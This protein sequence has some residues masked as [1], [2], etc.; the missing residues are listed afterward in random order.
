[1]SHFDWI[2]DPEER[3]ALRDK[4]LNSAN[5]KI[6]NL[7]GAVIV[8]GFLICLVLYLYVGNISNNKCVVKQYAD[9]LEVSNDSID[10]VSSTV[11]SIL[12]SSGS[13]ITTELSSIENPTKGEASPSYCN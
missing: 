8:L 6:T 1:M 2:E 3:S 4:S 11:G 10:D 7:W 9:A 13:D 5:A 12:N